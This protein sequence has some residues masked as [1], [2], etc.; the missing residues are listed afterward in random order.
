M[1]KVSNHNKPRYFED[2][3]KGEYFSLHVNIS[4]ISLIVE[5]FSFIL[6][7]SYIDKN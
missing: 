5:K 3:N 7:E 6:L 2:I 1:C 4:W